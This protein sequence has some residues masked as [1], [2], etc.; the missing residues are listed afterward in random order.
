VP[1]GHQIVA[2]VPAAHGRFGISCAY[3]VFSGELRVNQI[4]TTFPRRLVGA[5]TLES[6]TYEEVEADPQASAQAAAVVLLA[7][8]AGGIGLIGAG[9]PTLASLIAGVI[10]SL[11]GWVSWA[12]LTFFIGTRLLPEPQTKADVGELL[13]TIAFASAPGLLRVLGV[14][15]VVGPSIYA[16]VSIWMLVAMIVAV[17]QALDY[18]STARAVAV[19]IAGW[20][21]SLVI[22]AIIGVTFARTVS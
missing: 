3:V 6:R 10:G 1:S 9:V 22:A 21:L 4:M 20:A 7:S 5:A 19:C 18:R 17:R 8:I 15:P 11:L 2:I 12:A 14:V 13:R 16:F